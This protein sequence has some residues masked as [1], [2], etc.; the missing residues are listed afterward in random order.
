M[1]T[2]RVPAD[3]L[4]QARFTVSAKAEIVAALMTLLRPREPTERAFHAAHHAAFEAMLTA[5]PLRRAVLERS[6][7]PRRGQLPAWMA[8]Y[9]TAPPGSAT[10]TVHDEL[11]AVAATP[12]ETLRQDLEE[13]SLGELPPA[14]H[15]APVSQVAADL[16][17]WI[18]AHTLATDWQR[19]ERILSADVVGRTA[20]LATHGWAKVLHDLGRD[21]EWVGDG[22]L[23][24]NRYDLP[25]RTLP[26]DARLLFI[27]VFSSG[28]WVGWEEL[29][30]YAIYYPVAGRLADTG[31][32]RAG[33][34]DRLLG[35]NRATLLRLLAE[36]AGT[37]HLAGRTQLPVGSVGDHLRVLLDAGIVMRRRSGR[38]V[39]YWRTP[40]GDALVAANQ[41][42]SPPMTGH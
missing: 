10:A 16:L 26:V 12:D 41:S 21:R 35:P 18:W 13:T 14:L 1:G 33:G 42:T 2:W 37:T 8:D 24:I 4:A 11:A 25:T 22:Q 36:P 40:L 34:L 20:Q 30:T 38:Y 19:R 7:R 29:T 17:D 32:T 9:L 3:L 6:F 39:L 28:S 31:T 27:P 23:R 5:L 15:H